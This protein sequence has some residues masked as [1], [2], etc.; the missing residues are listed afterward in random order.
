MRRKDEPTFWKVRRGILATSIRAD[1]QSLTTSPEFL[2]SKKHLPP[3]DLGILASRNDRHVIAMET[4]LNEP[5]LI[6]FELHE[7]RR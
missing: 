4:P 7:D 2:R 5:H 1:N 3:E 6:D